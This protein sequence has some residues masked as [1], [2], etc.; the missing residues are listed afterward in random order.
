MT[1][2]VRGV[3]RASTEAT[4]RLQ[5]RLV[6]VGE[7]G[8]AARV[9]DDV[10]GRDK[11]Q[12]GNNDLVARADAGAEYGEVQRGG[13]TGDGQ[14]LGRADV[15]GKSRSNSPSRARASASRRAWRRRRPRFG[16]GHEGWRAE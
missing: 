11:R 13:P 10:G 14:R 7:D 15:R 16:L 2:L 12:G 3:M 9:D 4:S 8:R 1:A 5:G 6:H